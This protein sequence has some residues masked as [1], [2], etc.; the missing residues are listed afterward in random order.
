MTVRASVR[1][2][3]PHDQ[4]ARSVLGAQYALSRRSSSESPTRTECGVDV[5][6]EGA[7]RMRGGQ[8]PTGPFYA[9]PFYLAYPDRFLKCRGLR[10]RRASDMR[11]HLRDTEHHQQPTHCARCGDIFRGKTKYQERDIHLRTERCLNKDFYYIGLTLDQMLALRG[12]C[13]LADV[14]GVWTDEERR[15]FRIWDIVFPERARPSSPYYDFDASYPSSYTTTGF[16]DPLDVSSPA[17]ASDFR[18]NS[19]SQPPLQTPGLSGLTTGRP[20]V[21][22]QFSSSEQ[23]VESAEPFQAEWNSGHGRIDSQGSLLSARSPRAAPGAAA[24][25][26]TELRYYTDSGDMFYSTSYPQPVTQTPRQRT[27]AGVSVSAQRPSRRRGN[28]GMQPPA[29]A[30]I[31]GLFHGHSRRLGEDTIRGNGFD[32]M[33]YSHTIPV[34]NSENLPLPQENITLGF[35]PLSTSDSHHR[36]PTFMSRMPQLEDR[37]DDIQLTRSGTDAVETTDQE[38]YDHPFQYSFS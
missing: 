5:G 28:I 19:S 38:S 29:A 7:R 16:C 2:G 14:Q 37:N 31:N 30:P 6:S 12:R 24:E 9:C 15:W 18:S 23:V 17:P 35:S 8:P 22:F 26:P 34:V 11:V 1:E 3:R 32:M 20:S 4:G 13:E 33:S 10:I 21:G 27:Q 25:R 36:D